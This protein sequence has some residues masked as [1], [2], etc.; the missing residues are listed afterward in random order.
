MYILDQYAH[1]L[2]K[3]NNWKLGTKAKL[4]EDNRKLYESNYEKHKSLTSNAHDR[5]K[6]KFAFNRK[7]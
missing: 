6:A 2:K 1:L 3:N 5:I 7:N 4:S